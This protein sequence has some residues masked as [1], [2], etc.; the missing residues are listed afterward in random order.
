VG[1]NVEKID[2]AGM[3]IF[4]PVRQDRVDHGL[5]A[6]ARLRRPLPIVEHLLRRRGKKNVDRVLA[7]DGGDV[8]VAW[9]TELPTDTLAMPMR[10][11]IGALISVKARLI[12]A[13]SRAA[14]AERTA[15]AAAPS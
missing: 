3:R 11:S 12:L 13:C 8:P 6:S 10:P 4:L 14:S 1:L 5:G 2:R 7:D 9:L 15:A